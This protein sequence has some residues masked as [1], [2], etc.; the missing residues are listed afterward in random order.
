MIH[1]REGAKP[2]GQTQVWKACLLSGWGPF[3]MIDMC[4]ALG[5]EPVITTTETST[6]QVIMTRTEQYI[7]YE[8]CTW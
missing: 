4:N 1:F 8:D 5:I 7:L 3:E 2:F 6:A